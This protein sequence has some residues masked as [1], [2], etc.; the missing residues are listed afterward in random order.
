MN[1]DIYTGGLAET[2]GYLIQTESACILFDAPAGIYDWLKSRDI[3]VTHL[4]L[5]H[6]HWDHCHDVSLFQDIEILAFAEHDE[7]LILQRSFK[8][9]YGI[10]LNIKP[11]KVTQ[12]ISHE[13]EIKIV[14]VAL[15]AHHVPGH[16]TDSLAFHCPEESMCIA[17]DVLFYQS[18][19]R[20]DLP[21]GDGEKLI[22]SIENVMF[23]LPEDTTIFPGHGPETTIEEEKKHNPYK[24]IA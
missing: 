10:D 8:Q 20:V 5:T 14:D 12:L 9:R 7:D 11:F 19:G 13:Q 3:K 21:G 4:L 16:S 18:C 17:G 15:T 23:A 24:T 22:K 6:L 1:I 2:N